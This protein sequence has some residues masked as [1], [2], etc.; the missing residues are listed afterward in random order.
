M[1]CGIIHVP[2]RGGPFRVCSRDTTDCRTSA[3]TFPLR[4]SVIRS[5]N[6]NVCFL[7]SSLC[8]DTV[9]NFGPSNWNGSKRRKESYYLAKE[10]A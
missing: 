7:F 9:A 4:A 5:A 3:V 10:I 8:H 6:L 2:V 1:F